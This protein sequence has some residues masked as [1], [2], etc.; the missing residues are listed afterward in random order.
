MKVRRDLLRGPTICAAPARAERPERRADDQGAKQIGRGRRSDPATKPSPSGGSDE[1]RECLA[2]RVRGGL[3][4][5]FALR[6]SPSPSNPPSDRLAKAVSEGSRRI[7]FLIDDA[8]SLLGA[9]VK[10]DCYGEKL[11]G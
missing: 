3:I 11:D 8:M 2:W 5:R 7:H 4:R 10:E 9:S 6:R 1:R